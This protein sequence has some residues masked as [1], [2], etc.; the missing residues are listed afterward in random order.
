MNSAGPVLSQDL[1]DQLFAWAPLT[2]GII[3]YAIF[4]VAKRQEV[5]AGGVPIGQTYACATC[6]RRGHREHMVPTEHGGAVSYNC[7]N[8]AGGH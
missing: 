1:F 4:Y 6:G 8:C 2:I 7:T 3:I 5:A